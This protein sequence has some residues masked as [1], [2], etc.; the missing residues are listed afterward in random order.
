MNELKKKS[1]YVY[2]PNATIELRSDCW[3]QDGYKP[4]D[5]EVIAGDEVL[6]CISGDSIADFTSDLTALFEKY[7]I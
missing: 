7:S 3:E 6:F 5:T 2:L 4:L 1:Q